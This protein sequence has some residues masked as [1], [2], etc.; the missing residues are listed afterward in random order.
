[1]EVRGQPAKTVP[2]FHYVDARDQTVRLSS[3]CL[4]PLSHAMGPMAINTTRLCATTMCAWAE[5]KG[6]PMSRFWGHS[7]TLKPGKRQTNSVL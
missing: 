4:C 1:M 7:R 2:S 6:S 3:K 5:E